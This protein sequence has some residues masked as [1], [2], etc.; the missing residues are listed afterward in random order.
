MRQNLNRNRKLDD[1]KLNPNK[2]CILLVED[3]PSI[4]DTMQMVLEAMDFEVHPAVEGQD[5][6]GQI[7]KARVLPDLVITDLMMP[8]VTGWELVDVL[9]R[10][11]RTNKIPI[12]VYSG[13][14]HYAADNG[15]LKEA[16][17]FFLRKPVELDVL[18]ETIRK[19]LTGRNPVGHRSESHGY[20]ATS[21][22]NPDT[23]NA[24]TSEG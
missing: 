7:A 4:R 11:G 22:H 12:I 8:V 21:N 18:E 16:G 3:D 17:C 10:L 9:H 13:V 20:P 24:G 2:V 6:L 14:A 1:M 15:I 5:A 23:D 19:A